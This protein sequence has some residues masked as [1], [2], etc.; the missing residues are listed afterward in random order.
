MKYRQPL[1]VVADRADDDVGGPGRRIFFPLDMLCGAPCN[2]EGGD[3]K[4]YECFPRCHGLLTSL[5]PERWE[6][7]V[8]PL[9]YA[10]M[11]R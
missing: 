10:R 5:A 11:L 6:A 9:T 7:V 3:T 4:T 2:K 1:V 8:L